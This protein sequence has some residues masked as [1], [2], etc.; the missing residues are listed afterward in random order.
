MIEQL[1]AKYD[2]RVPRYTSYPTAPHFH[3][4]IGAADYRGWLGA[5]GEDVPLSLY[6]HIPFCDSLCWFCGCHT[7]IVRRYEPIAAY[8]ELLHAEIDVIAGELGSRR[9][10]VH[11]HLGGGTPTIVSPDDMRRLFAHLRE[12]FDFLPEA[13]LA[14]E[15]DPRD[16]HPDMVATLAEVGVNRASLGV[17]DINPEVQE[18]VN[19]IQPLEQT[20]QLIEELRTA[21]IESINLDLVYGLPHQT[22]ELVRATVDAVVALAPQRLCI[23]GY[24][25][26]PWMKRHQRMIDEAT[27]PGAAARFGQYRTAAAALEAAGYVWIGLDH[28]ALP[29]DE[30]ARCLES[31]QLHRN[32]Q[33]YTTDAAPARLGFGASA[34]GALPQGF[35]QNSAPIHDYR[36]RVLGGAAPIVRGL[37][38]DQEDR[39]RGR[40]IE[41]LMCY[42]EVDVAATAARFGQAPQHFAE[43]WERLGP[44]AEDGLIT[45]EDWRVAMTDLGRPFVRAVC[46][47]F[48]SY[49]TEGEQRHARAV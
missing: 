40:L 7:K 17:Q 18:A 37:A 22:D 44:L 10:V 26:V 19:R 4:G 25:H 21:G 14:V 28:F 20:R 41:E 8:L 2:Q 32:F 45:R 35:I 39:L 30:M 5:L 34:I 3:G 13:D 42:L 43:E 15:I 12:V 46:A 16:I 9:P 27:L 23:F 47:A 31:R 48:D 6:F 11:L 38:L 33:G 49:L 29:E 24:A 1:L 36:D